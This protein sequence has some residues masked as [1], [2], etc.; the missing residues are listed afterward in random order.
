MKHTYT[1]TRCRSDEG[2]SLH[3]VTLLLLSAADAPVAFHF[4]N[5]GKL[6]SALHL[7]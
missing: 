2:S 5:I 6:F 1:H 3:L 7:R 4:S